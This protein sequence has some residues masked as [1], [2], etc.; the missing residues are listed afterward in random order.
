LQNCYHLVL[1]FLGPKTITGERER[2]R[3][4][5]RERERE[6]EKERE[7]ERERDRERETERD[8]EI[9]RLRVKGTDTKWR[10]GC[11]VFILFAV[12]YLPK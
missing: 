11:K 9:E 6:R 3:K 10:P 12:N 4:R 5:E 1:S 7:R 2:E 8:I